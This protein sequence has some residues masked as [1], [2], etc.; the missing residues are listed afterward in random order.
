LLDF[1]GGVEVRHRYLAVSR[2]RRASWALAFPDE[3]VIA[4]TSR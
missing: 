1:A 3:A 4:C 2:R